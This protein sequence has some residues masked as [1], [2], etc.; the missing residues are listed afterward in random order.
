M[1]YIWL[2]QKNRFIFN[3]SMIQ[4][5]KGVQSVTLLTPS[6]RIIMVQWKMGCISNSTSVS[7]VQPHFSNYTPWFVGRDMFFLRASSL[8]LWSRLFF[9]E[10]TD[11]PCFVQ[12]EFPHTI[13]AM[14]R[15]YLHK[16]LL[17]LPP[18]QWPDTTL[19]ENKTKQGYYGIQK[20]KTKCTES[21]KW[22]L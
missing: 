12:P 8:L 15:K 19:N 18:P 10:V 9:A 4:G 13:G 16:H 22:Y 5:D 3:I 1:P 21:W 20:T 11:W 17:L 6:S 7:K 14:H 2:L